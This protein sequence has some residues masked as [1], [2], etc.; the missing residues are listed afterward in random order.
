MVTFDPHPQA[1]L[2]GESPPRLVSPS[3][4]LALLEEAG[5]EQV[6]IIKFNKRLSLVEPEDFVEKLLIDKIGAKAIVVGSVF[7][8]GHKARGDTTM[9]RSLARQLGFE[10][11]AVRLK[12][13]S[14]RT[15]S[16]T[17]IRHALTHGDLSWAN[18][19]LGRSYFLSGKV[20]KGSGRGHG[21]GFPTANIR[22]EKDMCL[23]GTGIYAGRIHIGSRRKPAAISIG[24]NP[25]FGPNP[26]SVEAFILDFEGNLYGREVSLEFVRRLR[27]EK[28]Y[29]TP[30]ALT[31]AIASDVARTRRLIG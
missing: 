25:T 22:A 3:R 31:R 26:L 1:V 13:L 30:E 23:P 18:R 14:G 24:T 12:R 11:E 21:L 2:R 16:S 20:R 27:D 8:F 19:A 5:I 17:A 28:T 6:I 29:A 9:M 15:V 4:R 7:R 10:F